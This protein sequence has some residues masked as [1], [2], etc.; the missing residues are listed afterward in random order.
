[1]PLPVAHALCGDADG[2]ADA[3]DV[4]GLLIALYGDHGVSPPAVDVGAPDDEMAYTA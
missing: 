4:S 2:D 3:S 1:M